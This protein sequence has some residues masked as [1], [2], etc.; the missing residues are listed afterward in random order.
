MIRKIF[1][2]SLILLLAACATQPTPQPT[3][4][5]F[6]GTPRSII[7]DTDMAADDWMA[8]LYLLQRP[9]INIKAITVTGTGESHCKPG[10]R[11]ALSLAMLAGQLD[12]PVTCGRETPLQ[13]NHTFPSAWRANVDALAGLTLPENPTSPSSKSAV[14][15]MTTIIQSLPEK[16]TILTLGPLT[17]LAEA[18]QTTPEIR[19]KIEMVYIMGGA[20]DVA[21]NVGISGVGID[22][23]AAEWNIYCDP[24]A[25]RIVFESGVPITLIPLDATNHVPVTT[26]F[27]KR[28]KQ[29]HN[30]PAAQFVFEVLTTN[31]DFI[32]SGSYYF[33]D[34][35]AAAVLTD[36]SLVTF[37]N[38]MLT[39]IEE[40]G[41]ESG[42]TKMSGDG[43]SIRVAV[44]A[45]SQGFEQLFLDTLNV[46]K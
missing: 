1:N 35:L 42:R 46:T 6:T 17:N 3:P 43:A 15:L 31:Y 18:L 24:Q 34:P 5:P 44:N 10:I 20:V 38:K 25:A 36:N 29:N 27:F 19:D 11:H 33:W 39:V 14:G 23:Q 26:S 45:D 21:G 4:I 41:P 40:E 30:T 7:I 13:G 28:L 37:E 2:L 8:I 9:D 32:Q 16:V 22:N 12:I